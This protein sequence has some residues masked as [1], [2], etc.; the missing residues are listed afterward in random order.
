MHKYLNQGTV[1]QFTLD[2]DVYFGS[3]RIDDSKNPKVLLTLFSDAAAIPHRTYPNQLSGT[4]FDLTN[5]TLLDS[6]FMGSSFQTKSAFD[7]G[8]AF[9]GQ[10]TF[11]VGHVLFSGSSIDATQSTFNSLDFSITNSNDLFYFSSFTEVS[12]F[13]E[14]SV[15]A[16]IQEDLDISKGKYG[17]SSDISQYSFGGSPIVLVYTG[18]RTLSEL[19]IGNAKLVIRNNL[20]YTLPSNNGFKFE[21]DISC[22]LEFENP[23]DYWEIAREVSSIKQ[24]FELILGHKQSLSSY[25]LEVKTP[26]EDSSFFKVFREADHP[27]ISNGSIH[28][29]TRL[30]H[31][32]SEEDEFSTLINN[33]VSSGEEWKFSRQYYFSI[34]TECEYTSDNL[35]KL[36]NMFDLIPDSAYIQEDIASEVIEAAQACRQIF[37]PLPQSLERNAILF[38]LKRIGQK[39]LK[40][41]IRDRYEIIRCSGF[42]EL[43]DIEL[44]INQSVDC[45]NFFV[46]GGGKRFDYFKKFDEFCFFIDTLIF[47][48]GVSEMIQNGWTFNKWK[49][50]ALNSHPFSNYLRNYDESLQDLKEALQP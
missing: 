36:A 28:P 42:I 46:H 25:I 12:H 24:L 27:T 41:K 21:N 20:N 35:V 3:L 9:S 37:K 5:V 50:G 17:F 30:V 49:A 10:L 13:N 29:A 40:H 26:N 47:I 48:Y 8:H 7:G 31:V 23:K 45:R 15:K 6:I 14:Q 43:D 38:A 22:C 18:A 33:W 39:S 11:D 1:G 34:F 2:D 19:N 32:E 16:L 44:V 4:L